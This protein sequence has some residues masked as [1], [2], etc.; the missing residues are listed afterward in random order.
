MVMIIKNTHIY[1]GKDPPV[2]TVKSVGVHT[3][4]L[5]GYETNATK[6]FLHTY[7]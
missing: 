6:I 1:S 4:I 3:V 5:Q 2:F 7:H